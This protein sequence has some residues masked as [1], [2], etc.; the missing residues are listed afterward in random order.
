MNGAWDMSGIMNNIVKFG[1]GLFLAST[2]LSGAAAAQDWTGPYIGAEAGFGAFD[3]NVS[4]VACCPTPVSLDADLSGALFGIEAGYNI[5]LDNNLVAG[6]SADWSFS[7]IDGDTG[8]GNPFIFEI[9]SLATLQA[10]FGLAVGPTNQ[11]LLFI[12]GGIARA[13]VTVSG[14]PATV[15]N[16]HVGYIVTTGAEHRISDA[17]SVK[18][19]V[20]YVDLGKETYVSGE[21]VKLDGITGTVGVNFHF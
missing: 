3:A 9:D 18:A 12:G 13:D 19:D 6:V 16:N 14:Y 10:R 5:Q 7:T 4:Y 21:V 15:S 17:I 8:G 2:A 1:F 11:T 20:S